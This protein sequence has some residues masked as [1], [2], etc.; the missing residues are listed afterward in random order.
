MKILLWNVRGLGSDE[1]WLAVKD[2][3]CRHKVQIVLIQESKLRGMSDT[4]AR[5]LWGPSYVKWLPVDVVGSADG[6]IILWDAPG[7]G[8]LTFVNGN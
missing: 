1:R 8:H 3:I 6:I 5:A 7:G 4:I 2:L